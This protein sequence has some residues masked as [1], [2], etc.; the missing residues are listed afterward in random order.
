MKVSGCQ[1]RGEM[2]APHDAL[3]CALPASAD[4]VPSALLGAGGPPQ[5]PAT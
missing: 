4:V 3:V 1:G 2:G 5:V